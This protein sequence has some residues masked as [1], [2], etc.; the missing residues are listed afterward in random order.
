M[1]SLLENY[2]QQYAIVNADITSKIGKLKLLDQNDNGRRNIMIEIDKQIEEVQ[3]L[4]E[5]MDLEIRE[6]DPTTRPKY[7]TRID[8][9]RAELER[10]SQE[11]SK[12][13]LPK[14]NTEYHVEYFSENSTN[15][16]EE[17]SQRLL[18][19]SEEIERTGKHLETGYRIAI[20]TEKIATDVLKDL[21]SQ[22]ETLQRTRTRLRETNED[23]SRSSRIISVIIS[24]SLHHR[25]IL[26]GVGITFGLVFIYGIYHAFA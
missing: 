3:E 20:E 5:Q 13:K 9:Y 21:E 18:D 22:R 19:T 17:Q 1:W 10:L 7:K 6:V 25:L 14:N 23:L 16:N 15:I 4:M 11:Y 8:S 26:M 2:E 12:A 24:R